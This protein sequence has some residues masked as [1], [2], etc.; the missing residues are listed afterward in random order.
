MVVK[1]IERWIMDV[2]YVRKKKKFFFANHIAQII[3]V[4][5]AFLAQI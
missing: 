4:I 1:S 3:H 2:L 5:V